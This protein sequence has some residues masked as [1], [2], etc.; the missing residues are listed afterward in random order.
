MNALALGQLLRE[1]SLASAGAQR[2]AT[3]EHPGDVHRD[4]AEG[5]LIDGGRMPEGMLL[6]IDDVQRKPAQEFRDVRIERGMG[7]VESQM[8]FH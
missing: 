2:G 7:D 3:P 4:L 6:M 8:L 5:K 1:I